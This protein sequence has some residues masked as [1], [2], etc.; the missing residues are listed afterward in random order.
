MHPLLPPTDPSHPTRPLAAWLAA[1]GLAL[2]AWAL[3]EC[4]RPFRW[5][6]YQLCLVAQPLGRALGWESAIEQAGHWLAAPE[7]LDA[8]SEALEGWQAPP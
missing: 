7:P 8:L 4:V 2:P 1:R 6:L 5:T 3:L